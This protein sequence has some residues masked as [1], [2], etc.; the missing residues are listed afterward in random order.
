MKFGTT[1]EQFMYNVHK[2]YR[3]REELV[4]GPFMI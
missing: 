2:F 3:Y 1:Y 4:P